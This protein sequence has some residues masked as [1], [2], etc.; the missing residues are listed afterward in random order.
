MPVNNTKAS[1]HDIAI[2]CSHVRA[3]KWQGMESDMHEVPHK[4][5]R[6]AFQRVCPK[7]G[8]SSYYRRDP[9]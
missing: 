1:E 6:S 4:T 8:C 9:E 2:K 3:C 7:C 5:I